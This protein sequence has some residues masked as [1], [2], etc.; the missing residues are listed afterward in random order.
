MKHG[1]ADSIVNHVICAD[2]LELLKIIPANTIEALGTP[3]KGK[4]RR[5]KQEYKRNKKQQQ[6]DETRKV[7]SWL[8]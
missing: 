8:A 5:A 3:S 1:L 4:R 7:D 6:V 2:S